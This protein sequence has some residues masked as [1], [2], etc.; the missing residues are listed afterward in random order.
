MT[1][2]PRTK[3]ATTGILAR[4]QP[5][6]PARASTWMSATVNGSASI[7]RMIP[8]WCEYCQTDTHVEGDR[9]KC[10]GWETQED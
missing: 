1:P 6:T 9:R 8:M 7:W 3:W 2:A 5:K 10:A 4:A